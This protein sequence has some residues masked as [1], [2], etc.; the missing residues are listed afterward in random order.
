MASLGLDEPVESRLHELITS[1][2]AGG[3][4]QDIEPE[5][6]SLAK[7][8]DEYNRKDQ[9]L[10]NLLDHVTTTAG[11]QQIRDALKP[12]ERKRVEPEGLHSNARDPLQRAIQSLLKAKKQIYELRNGAEYSLELCGYCKG[13]AH[14][15]LLMC[16]ACAGQRFVVVHQPAIVCPRCKGNGEADADDR[17]AFDREL[18]MVSRQGLGVYSP[19]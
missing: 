17:A 5:L 18:C 4:A 8:I 3:S 11:Q 2:S 19:G 1:L 14:R 9:L 15:N 10:E 7:L 16:P 13:F 12:L 6:T